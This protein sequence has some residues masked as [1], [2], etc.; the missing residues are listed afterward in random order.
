MT[1]V[2]TLTTYSQTPIGIVICPRS[3]LLNHSCAP[4]TAITFSGRTLNIH[5]LDPIE[6]GEELTINYVDTTCLTDTR[7]AELQERYFFTCSCPKC[8]KPELQPRLTARMRVAASKVLH[9]AQSAEKASD[10]ILKRDGS[11]P[12]DTFPDEEKLKSLIEAQNLLG[13]ANYPKYIHPSPSILDSTILTAIN[14]R[15]WLL[16]L[17]HALHRSIDVDPL[18]KPHQAWHP[19]RIINSWVL[20][21]LIVQVVNVTAENN[22]HHHHYYQNQLV[23][24]YYNYDSK[25]NVNHQPD[26]IVPDLQHIIAPDPHAYH[27]LCITMYRL[28]LTNAQKSHGKASRLVK[29]MESWAG[30]VGINGAAEEDTRSRTGEDIDETFVKQGLERLREAVERDLSVG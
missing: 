15:K 28:L 23:S 11:T 21:K 9:L 1:N 22:H 3:S 26:D 20:L 4:N 5:A 14:A 17:K 18:T 19:I 6:A 7:Q 27:M 8:A 25:T 13:S 2:H 10:H 29:E 12:E 30:E 24:P 16:A